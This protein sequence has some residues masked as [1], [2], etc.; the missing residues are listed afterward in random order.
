MLLAA[1]QPCLC[2]LCQPYAPP[3]IYVFIIN[4]SRR[5]YTFW[6]TQTQKI[7]TIPYYYV[8][9]IVT[10]VHFVKHWFPKLTGIG[11]EKR[12][13]KHDVGTIQS[14]LGQVFKEMAYL[15]S[16]ML[17]VNFLIIPTHQNMLVTDSLMPMHVGRHV[18]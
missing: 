9:T 10:P 11:C 16:I 8:R 13:A 2:C 17:N 7:S 3:I 15:L 14:D 6:N 1:F 4:S 5:M 18:S 12:H